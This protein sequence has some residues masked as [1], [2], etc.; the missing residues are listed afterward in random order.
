MASSSAVVHP[1]VTV[2]PLAAESVTVNVAVAVSGV[3]F[4]DGHV[5]HRE[6]GGWSSSVIV[7]M[8]EPSATVAF[9]GVARM[10]SNVSSSSSVTSPLTVTTICTPVDPAVIVP[11]VPA[12]A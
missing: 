9:D 6:A 4:G 8:P 2:L 11:L 12:A 7:P 5:V 1:T 3:P 10:M